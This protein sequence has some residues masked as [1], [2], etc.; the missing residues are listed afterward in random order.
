MEQTV[1]QASLDLQVLTVLLET[2]AHLVSQAPMDPLECEEHK[3]LRE[4][5]GSQGR[6]VRWDLLVPQAYKVHP[7]LLVNV[8][9]EESR[10][11]SD[12]VGPQD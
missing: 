10:D 8:V 1:H 9:S 2:E 3:D 11:L 7:D 4:R 12:L 6:R 5:E